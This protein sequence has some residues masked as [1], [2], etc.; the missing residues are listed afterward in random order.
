MFNFIKKI[1]MNIL[2]LA[3]FISVRSNRIWLF[4][5]Y[6]EFNDNSKY[7][8]L[9]LLKDKDVEVFWIAKNKKEYEKVLNYSNNCYMRFSLKGLYYS[10]RSGVYIYSA[11]V[12][13]INYISCGG[14]FK[15]NLWHGIPLKKIE[16]DIKNG[17]TANVF[18]NTFKSKF[19]HPAAYVRPNLVLCPS[20]FVAEYSFKSAFRISDNELLINKYPRVLSLIEENN[21]YKK[22]GDKFTF[23]YAPTWRDGEP[24]FLNEEILNLCE[25]QKFCEKYNCNFIVKLHSNTKNTLNYSEYDN[26]ELMDNKIDSNHAMIIS[27]CLITDYSS[28]YLDYIYLDKPMIFYRFDEEKYVKLSR[29]LYK[30]IYNYKPGLIASSLS[31]LLAI[32]SDVVNGLDVEIKDLNILKNKLDISSSYIN[33]SIKDTIIQR[34]NLNSSK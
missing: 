16:F 34:L 1:L 21:N 2:Y 32:M 27:D 28:I 20:Q 11:Y 9:S 3:S 5:S 30:D 6:G 15:V 19:Y 7:L 13:D 14:V 17:A 33:L 4:G 25:I 22:K 23:L 10:L 31:S 26:I 18:N 24:N 29:D 12:S 8:F